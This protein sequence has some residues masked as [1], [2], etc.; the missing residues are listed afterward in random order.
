MMKRVPF[1][2]LLLI[3]N[4]I[5]SGSVFPN[6][7]PDD[8]LYQSCLDIKSGLNVLNIS[9]KPG[10]ED[11]S[12]LAYYRFGQGA[13]IMSAYI[14]NGEC[15]EADSTY[16]YPH[17]IT[18][19]LKEESYYAISSLKGETYYLSFPEIISAEND[20]K[21]YS[22]W[23][24][25]SLKN[26]LYNLIST[27]KPDVILLSRD[28]YFEN[29][30]RSMD[31]LLNTIKEV[32]NENINW[33][34]S[35]LFY[36]DP[37]K[38]GLKIP[39]DTKDS[40]LKKSY[41]KIGEDARKHY[42]S[43]AQQIEKLKS[44]NVP[45]YSIIFPG[46]V[47]KINDLTAGI[48]SYDT[49]KPKIFKKDINNLAT[50]VLKNQKYVKEIRQL[51]DKQIEVLKYLSKLSD[52]VNTQLSY[53]MNLTQQEYKIFL[54]WKVNLD[55]IRNSLLGV[56]L[57][58]SISETILTNRQLTLLQIDSISGLSKNGTTELFFPGVDEDW[59][60]N[61]S[62]E[63]RQPLLL[64]QEYRIL[65]PANLKYS[66]PYEI[67]NMD[68]TYLKNQFYFFV[69]HSSAVK[70]ENFIYK[71]IIHLDYSPRFTA[72]I[73]TPLVF[74]NGDNEKFVFRLTNHSRDGFADYVTVSDSA[75]ISSDTINV[76]LSYKGAEYLDTLNLFFKEGIKVGDNLLELKIG[77]EPVANFVA[78]RYDIVVD[79]TKKV[80][81]ISSQSN[82]ITKLTL[83]RLNVKFVELNDVNLLQTSGNNLDVIIIDR[84]MI[85]TGKPKSFINELE[86]FV[87]A[88]GNLIVLSQDYSF[89]NSSNLLRDFKITRS[90]NIDEHSSI[91]RDSNNRI[92]NFPNKIKDE[93]FDNWIY[94]RTSNAVSVSSSNMMEFPVIASIDKTPLL[95]TQKYVNGTIIYVNMAL[96]YQ[97][98]N[99]HEGAYKILANLISF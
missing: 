79:H 86:A 59:V 47:K 4:I 76:K 80:G 49:K 19:K 97:L 69:I 90:F 37:S 15:T 68:K 25:D 20:E 73:L 66:Y 87:A 45:T 82:S 53:R 32:I 94:T 10:Y 88:G 63:K 6:N 54:N 22:L 27:F 46:N 26:K 7:K 85:V 40:R 55:K 12:A 13:K 3:A 14:T 62:S 44:R 29:K 41:H 61:E 39:V 51:T 23:N 50:T 58:Y 56:K 95:L 1:Y 33:K 30:N 91:N 78:R 98:L 70:E 48:P 5:A 65:S 24:E 84:N 75:F 99:I 38:K 11:L 64:G 93:D 52:S 2:I 81:L 60:I 74:A 42:K 18:A 43:I 77:G 67:Y 57:Y 72:E 17:Q 21:I 71:Q 36:D 31:I 96:H 83:Q 28:W 8:E 16:Y 9:L 34:V 92:L 89:W 35:R